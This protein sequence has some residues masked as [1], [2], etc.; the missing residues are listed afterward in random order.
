MRAYIEIIWFFLCSLN[1]EHIIFMFT[2]FIVQYIFIF[3]YKLPY[4]LHY[5]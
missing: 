5:L 2:H 1:Y 3:Y 4:L